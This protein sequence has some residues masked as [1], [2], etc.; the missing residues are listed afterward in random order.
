[1]ALTR[2]VLLDLDGTLLDTAPDIAQA[3]NAMLAEQGLPPL[4]ADTV[5]EFIGSGIPKLVERCLEA[6]G[7]PTSE[8]ALASFRVHYERLNGGASS[9]Y[10]GAAAALGR[11]RAA[12]LRL[13][14]VTN[15]AAA[16]TLP[17]LEKTGLAPFFDAV[18]AADQVGRRKPDPEPFLHA[19]RE[20]G[21]SPGE[22]VVI[23]DSANDAQG[24]RAAGCRV[25]LVCYGYSEGRDVREIDSDGVVDTLG[26]AAERILSRRAPG[27]R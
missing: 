22:A 10:P 20:L 17:L 25:L 24:A 13:A 16:Y 6:A 27:P 3:A 7:A 8:A 18:V 11:L 19:C 26:E 14:C 9:P 4:P 12:G 15:K 2:A 5:R 1:M 21:A 23:G